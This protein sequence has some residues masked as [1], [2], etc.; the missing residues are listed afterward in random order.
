MHCFINANVAVIIN[1][2]ISRTIAYGVLFTKQITLSRAA[3]EWNENA[4]ILIS[5]GTRLIRI[6]IV[7]NFEHGAQELAFGQPYDT[8]VARLRGT[9]RLP[10]NETKNKTIAK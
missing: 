2:V 1:A 6:G 8:P 4:D 7:P 9:R 5:T 3:R 10:R